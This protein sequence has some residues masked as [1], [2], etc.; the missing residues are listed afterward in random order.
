[1]TS[2][3]TYL[4][5]DLGTKGGWALAIDGSIMSGSM[6]YSVK[7]FEGG[8]MRFLRFRRFLQDTLDNSG[9]IDGVFFE[10]V[11]ARQPSVAADQVWGGFKA[12][13]TAWCDEADIPYMGVPVAT[14]KKHVG[15]SGRG[16][17]KDAMVASAELIVDRAV[18]TSDEADAVILL[19]YAIK[20]IAPKR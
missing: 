8:G 9:G 19:D 10:E 2:S 7:K 5:L 16:S 1:M 15:V 11:K 18:A 14:I 12:T 3:K 13:L 6:D 17:Q 20:E 4:A